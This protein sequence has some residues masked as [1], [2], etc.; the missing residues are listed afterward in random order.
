LPVSISD[1]EGA[2]ILP[3]SISDAEGDG[4]L[5]RQRLGSGQDDKS[6]ET[7]TRRASEGL[8]F[9]FHGAATTNPRRHQP[10]ALAR[11]L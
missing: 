3:V 5:A 9:R 1:A 10:D 2:G 4:H 6:A 7:P 8:V 11:D